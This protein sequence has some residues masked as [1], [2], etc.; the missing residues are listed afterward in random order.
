MYRYELYNVDDIDRLK[1][2]LDSYKQTVRTVTEGKLIK[3]YLKTKDDFYD[4]KMEIFKL[5]G[6][7][8]AMENNYQEK[9]YNH[10]MEE[11]YLTKQLTSITSSLQQLNQK[12]QMIKN[13]FEQLPF[14]DLSEKIN[15]LINTQN[16]KSEEQKK[17]LENVIEE[18]SQ[19]KRLMKTKEEDT[20]AKNSRSVKRSEY[21]QLQS[22]LQFPNNVE[23]SLN[24]KKNNQVNRQKYSFTK[25]NNENSY[26]V[27][28][29]DSQ[30][31]ETI[32][33]SKAK[34]TF[35]NA[36]YE[37]NKNIITRTA[38]PN[39]K[40]QDESKMESLDTDNTLISYE[41][42]TPTENDSSSFENNVE[43]EKAPNLEIEETLENNTESIDN[44]LDATNSNSEHLEESNKKPDFTS[45]LSLFKRG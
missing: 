12:V 39:N 30:D 34:K 6:E 21:K 36:Q 27:H 16:T 5:K 9:I 33:M 14:N 20:T 45:F 35:R 11:Q 25:P 3:D 26:C 13:Q 22:I 44:Q 37:I 4:L 43:E 19:I 17:E 28:H 7:M 41:D 42:H 2:E 10:Q 1:K 32:S 8:K 23:Q 40:S 15:Q 18:I 31:S 29:Y 38:T 24:K